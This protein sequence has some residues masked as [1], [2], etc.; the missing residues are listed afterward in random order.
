MNKQETQKIKKELKKLHFTEFDTTGNILHF[1][2]IPFT[3]IKNYKDDNKNHCIKN[4]NAFVSFKAGINPN[5]VGD[6]KK[7]AIA[8]TYSI[9]FCIYGRQRDFR[10][11]EYYQKEFNKFYDYSRDL[12]ELIEKFK[13]HL[14]LNFN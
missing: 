3:G 4:S 13:K 2:Y 10:H 1:C 6:G 8:L 9:N 11:K 14:I 7:P 12:P 5:G